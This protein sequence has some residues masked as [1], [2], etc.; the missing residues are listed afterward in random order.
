MGVHGNAP[1]LAP[2][3]THVHHRRTPRPLRPVSPRCTLQDVRGPVLFLTKLDVRSDLLLSLGREGGVWG[4][5]RMWRL[6]LTVPSDSFTPKLVLSFRTLPTT[7]RSST[8]FP[9][10]P[11]LLGIS[12]LLLSSLGLLVSA[13]PVTSLTTFNLSTSSGRARFWEPLISLPRPAHSVGS[14]IQ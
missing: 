12:R 14:N 11:F 5:F 10:S 8:T 3:H 2:S 7:L 6:E 1:V 13:R 9:L 4:G